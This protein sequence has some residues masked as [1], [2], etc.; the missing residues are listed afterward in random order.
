VL[1]ERGRER[2]TGGW[3]RAEVGNGPARAEATSA[4]PRAEVA[5]CPEYRLASYSCN[6]QLIRLCPEMAP[7]GMSGAITH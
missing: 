1:G 7:V 2:P 3:A 5:S 6:F 4:E